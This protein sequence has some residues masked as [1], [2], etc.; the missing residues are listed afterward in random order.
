MNYYVKCCDIV[1]L[2]FCELEKVILSQY[3]DAT[4]EFSD[5]KCYYKKYTAKR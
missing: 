5:L 3:I 4:K 2:Y 1:D